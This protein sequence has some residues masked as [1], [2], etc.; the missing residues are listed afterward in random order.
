[1]CTNKRIEEIIKK[2]KE[3]TVIYNDSGKIVK[4]S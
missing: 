4:L 3:D 1:M 2:K